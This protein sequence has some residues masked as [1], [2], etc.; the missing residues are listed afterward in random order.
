MFA[1]YNATDCTVPNSVAPG[2][3][4]TV[5]CE[6]SEVIFMFACYNAT[7]C[8]GPNCAILGDIITIYNVIY[9]R[10]FDMFASFIM[11]RI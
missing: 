2:D 9:Q 7:D 5:F 11:L 6:M 8:M 10:V 3:I 4:I 1:Y